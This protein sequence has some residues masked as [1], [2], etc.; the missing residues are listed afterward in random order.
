MGEGRISDVRGVGM[1]DRD[2]VEE[3]GNDVEG[4]EGE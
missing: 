2:V 1:A 3:R 4:D